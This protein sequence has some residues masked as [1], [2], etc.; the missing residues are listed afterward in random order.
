M[1][2]PYTEFA[3]DE[4]EKQAKLCRKLFEE[5]THDYYEGDFSKTDFGEYQEQAQQ[6]DFVFFMSGFQAAIGALQPRVETNGWLDKGEN[7]AS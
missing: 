1:T 7:D 6:D 2:H 3:S 4:V 5:K